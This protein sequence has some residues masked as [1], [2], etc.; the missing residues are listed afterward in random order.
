M[1]IANIA[2]IQKA[3]DTDRIASDKA[4]IWPCL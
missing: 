3:H 4:T 2:R 1:M